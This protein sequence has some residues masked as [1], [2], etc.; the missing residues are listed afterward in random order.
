[1]KNTLHIGGLILLG[2]TSLKIMLGDAMTDADST[3]LIVGMAMYGISLM[4]PSPE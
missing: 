2:A 1:M 3:L 4:L